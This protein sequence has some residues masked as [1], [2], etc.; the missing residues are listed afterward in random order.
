VFTAVSINSTEALS[1]KIASSDQTLILGR[2]FL[3]SHMCKIYSPSF[4]RRSGTFLFTASSS[5]GT[6]FFAQLIL[7][8]AINAGFRDTIS[9]QHCLAD[10]SGDCVKACNTVATLSLLADVRGLPGRLLLK[11]C[12]VPSV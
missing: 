12:T 9:R 2:D 6:Y 11:F 4:I 5:L 1:L 7:Q 10:F 3:S 8:D